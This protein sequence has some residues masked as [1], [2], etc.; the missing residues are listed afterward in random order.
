M[1]IPNDYVHCH[2]CDFKGV[3]IRRPITLEYVLPCR[4]VVQGYRVSA[5]C[6]TCDNITDAEDAFDAASIQS[7]IDSLRRKQAGDV[8]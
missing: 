4:T 6:S 8:V 5:W 2:G 3:I 7:E 1:S